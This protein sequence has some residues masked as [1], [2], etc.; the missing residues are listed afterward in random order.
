[1]YEGGG[2]LKR[3]REETGGTERL[4]KDTE[5]TEKGRRGGLRKN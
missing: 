4:Q 1:V 3:G 2:D 5:K